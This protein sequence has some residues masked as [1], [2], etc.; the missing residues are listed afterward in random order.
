MYR[1]LFI[2]KH[3]VAFMQV[4][5]PA[6]QFFFASS[7]H[8]FQLRRSLWACLY[9]KKPNLLLCITTITTFLSVQY[10]KI[11]RWILIY[12]IRIGYVKHFAEF[13]SGMVFKE[14]SLF[15]WEALACFRRFWHPVLVHERI[16]YLIWWIELVLLLDK[17]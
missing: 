7:E 11:N 15:L 8:W 1:L 10:F 2:N 13:I 9:S 3:Y 16:N 6:C 12:I 14:E 4:L 17:I 5:V